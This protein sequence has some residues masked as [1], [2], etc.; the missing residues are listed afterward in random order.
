MED[1]KS[2]HRVLTK[3]ELNTLIVAA[4][5]KRETAE[6][7]TRFPSHPRQTCLAYPCSPTTAEQTTTSPQ[8]DGCYGSSFTTW[9]EQNLSLG[10]RSFRR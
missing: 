4:K 8:S 6:L 10:F 7:H 3:D 5:I 1:L 9:K 2:G